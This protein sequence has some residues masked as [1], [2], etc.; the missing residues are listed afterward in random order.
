MRNIK[1]MNRLVMCFSDFFYSGHTAMAV[2]GGLEVAA[3][4]GVLWNIIGFAVVFF[5]AFTVL[6]LHAHYTMDVSV[7]VL[8]FFFNCHSPPPSPILQ[9]FTGA[10]AALWLR[11]IASRLAVHVDAFFEAKTNSRVSKFE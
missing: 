7:V 10:I 9:V 6:L 2:L 1:F 8:E 3:I 4:G 11:E 5:E